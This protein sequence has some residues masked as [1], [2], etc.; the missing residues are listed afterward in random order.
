MTK[1]FLLAL[2]LFSAALSSAQNIATAPTFRAPAQTL[3]AWQRHPLSLHQ[4]NVLLLKD[5]SNTMKKLNS[6]NTFMQWY[7]IYFPVPFGS[8]SKETSWLFGLS[9]YNAFKIRQDAHDTIV[10]PSSISAFGYYTLNTQY[11]MVLESNLML[12]HNKAIWKTDL[13]YIYYPLLFYGVGNQT[14]LE[15]QRV[16]NTLNFQFSTF[17]LF[18][19]WK[20]WYVGPTF[21]YYNYKQVELSELSRVFAGDSAAVI[22]AVGRQSGLGLKISMEGR[23]NRLNAKRGFFFDA[24]YQFFDKSLGSQYN[25][26][27][28]QLDARYYFRLT[29]KIVLAS[30][31]RTESKQGDVPVQS[32][33][34]LGGD[35][36]MRGS[37][38]GRYRDN[39]SVIGQTEM[40]FPLF[41]I[42]GGTAFGGL[43]QVAP[44]YSKLN[45]SSFH[46][47]YGVGLRLQ[48]DNAHDINLRFDMGFSGDEALFIMNFSEAF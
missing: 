41:W 12:K 47:N 9:K 27:Y 31:L 37:Y 39:V 40:R 13:I 36:F 11:K 10:Q 16:L 5:T 48:V 8:Y 38:L 2:L 43:G 6:M 23:D 46:S 42:F 25:Y 15:Q 45:M 19:V 30:Q 28:F 21:D 22:H 17:Y 20:K 3:P 33:A 7:M 32:L 44:D 1:H 4:H 18:R 14:K 24:S 26:D 35:Y 29:K 34:F